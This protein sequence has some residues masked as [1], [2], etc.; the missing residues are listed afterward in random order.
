MD[1]VVAN[2][3]DLSTSAVVLMTFAN[4]LEPDRA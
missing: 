2:Q 4:S 1:P 3:S